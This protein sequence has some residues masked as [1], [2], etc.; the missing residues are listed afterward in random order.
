LA[1]IHAEIARFQHRPRTARSLYLDAIAC[2]KHQD[3]T[4]LTGHIYECF[5]EFLLEFQLDD[6]DLY[7]AE[8]YRLYES[9]HADVKILLL[10]EHYHQKDIY[11]HYAPKAILNKE[12]Q[13]LP[14]LDVNY[15]M[16]SA[17]ALSAETDLELLLQK[18]MTVVLECSGA[19]HGYLLIKEQDDLVVAAE[20]HI[21]KQ[22]VL[23]PHHYSMSKASGICP[24]IV[25]YVFRTQEKIVLK[26]ACVECDFNQLPEAQELGL[27]SVLCLPVIKQGQLIGVLYLE[28]RLSTGIFTAEKT[29]MTELLTSHAAISLEN[30]RLLAETHQAYEQLQESREH[31]MQMEKLS[32]LGTLVGGVAH[33]INNPLMGVMNYVEFAQEKTTDA[34][35]AKILGSAL[36]EI[37]RIKSIVRNM[38][39]YVRTK[40]NPTDIC[41][42]EAT[43]NQTLFLLE[44]EFKKSNVHIEVNLVN[45]LPAICFSADSLQQV[46]INLLLNARD[47]LFETKQPRIDINAQIV[48]AFLELSICDN[49]TGIPDAIL[50]RIFDPFFTTKPPGKGTGLGLSVTHRLIEEAGG[51]IMGYN[52]SDCGCCMK[53]QFKIAI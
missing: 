30:A 11:T 52:K 47:A 1:F 29:G 9:C 26:D 28:N 53:L 2:A 6:A 36:H 15:L 39:I 19:Q 8:A 41:H 17:L 45:N 34:K 25:N 4:L 51:S 3:Y 22:P 18:I 33:E 38:L 5:G 13:T 10:Q 23:K 27:R 50:T 14:N 42:I 35:I 24:S 16:K 21:G 40:S 43:L 46:L 12:L 48:G 37:G 31:M 32:A 49:G 7:Y 44:G 20:H